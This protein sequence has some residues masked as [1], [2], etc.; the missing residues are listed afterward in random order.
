MRRNVRWLIFG[1]TAAAFG[2]LAEAGWTDGKNAANVMG[3]PDF[4]SGQ[5]NQGFASPTAATLNG[6]QGVALDPTSGK[7]FVCDSS[8]SRVLR[9]P[10]PVAFVT[11]GSAEAVFGQADFTTVTAGIQRNKFNNPAGITLDG[12]GN[13]WV[14]D[15]I[16]NRV[17]MFQNAATKASGADADGLLGAVT[18]IVNPSGNTD[19]QMRQPQDIAVDGSGRVWVAD[20]QNHRILRF[21]NGAADAI[22]NAEDAAQNLALADGV[23][24][25]S[26]FG[27]AQVNRGSGTPVRN[28]MNLPWKI[29]IDASG[30]LW[31]ADNSN[32]RVL[33]FIDPAAKANGAD[34]DG[35]LGQVNFTTNAGPAAQRDRFWGTRGLAVD[36]RGALWVA[37]EFNHRVV[38][39][40]GAAAAALANAADLV[41]NVSLPDGVIGQADFV[42]TAQNN[43][44]SAVISPWDVDTSAYGDVWVA[45]KGSVNGG[46]RVSRFT[47]DEDSY[48]SDGSIGAKEA[49]LKGNQVYNLTGGGQKVT[50]FSEDRKKVA[51]FA[52]GGNDGEYADDFRILGTENNRDFKVKYYATSS[53]E[54]NITADVK[55][56]GFIERAVLLGQD[57]DYLLE[58]KPKASTKGKVKKFN[59]SF[60]I[61]SLRGNSEDRVKCTVKT[62]K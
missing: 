25:Q 52:R 34:A 53:G 17:V 20:W 22:A 55:V 23:L 19:G 16:N 5:D 14:A 11:G 58:V 57:R 4:A 30:D 40:D 50:V 61:V 41:E 36:S 26:G 37:E 2:S 1:M 38:R 62:R 28:G 27:L 18:F 31:V 13:L 8:N 46:H 32:N 43:I 59:L 60:G 33:Y 15:N 7:L 6:P 47:P 29:E 49:G 39:F 54:R 10:S 42:T 45:Q 51:V 12:A 21:D 44:G 3:Q 56:G 9:Y 24:G 35:L 48:R